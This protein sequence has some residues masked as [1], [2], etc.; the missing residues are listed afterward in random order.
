L[1]LA[2]LSAS[3]FKSAYRAQLTD[4]E[5]DDYAAST[6]SLDSIDAELND[7]ACKFLLAYEGDTVVGYALL[8]TGIPPN[9]V[10]GGKPV[11]LAR[12][13]L[14][15][16]VIGRG[17]GTALMEACLKTAHQDGYET[18]WLGVWEKNERAIRFYE[19]YGFSTVGSI[20]FEFGREVQT[21]LV[22]VRS[23]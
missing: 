11:E 12:I 19:K 21:D 8:R 3:T 7:P 15:E 14:T 20:A 10:N 13:Y 18:I 17:Y 5:L 9:G 23:I 2:E 22:M 1:L 16:D 4:K 6:F